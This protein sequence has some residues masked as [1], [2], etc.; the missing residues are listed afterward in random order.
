[1]IAE[2]KRPSFIHIAFRRAS[3]RASTYFTRFFS[4]RVDAQSIASLIIAAFDRVFVRRRLLER[5]IPDSALS[6]PNQTT[7]S[8]AMEASK[9]EALHATLKAS[10]PKGGRGG[11]GGS[12]A[13]SKG[14]RVLAAGEGAP[15]PDNP[16]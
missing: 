9:L 8:C 3:R 11:L 4:S 13:E 14:V 6:Q 16:L 10:A 12:G 2:W 15:L 7:P 5:G 1:M